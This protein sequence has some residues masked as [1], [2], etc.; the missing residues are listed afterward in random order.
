[1]FHLN[2]FKKSLAKYDVHAN[3]KCSGSESAYNKSSEIKLRTIVLLVTSNRSH[4]LRVFDNVPRLL[5]IRVGLQ[6]SLSSR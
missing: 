1:M 2:A 3:F 4:H 5:D 6:G